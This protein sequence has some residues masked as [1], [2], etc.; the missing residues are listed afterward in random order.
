MLRRL[1]TLAL[2]AA[3]ACTGAGFAAHHT[4]EQRPTNS[5]GGSQPAT[6]PVKPPRSV[7]IVTTEL[8]NQVAV[9]RLPSLRIARRIDVAADPKTV[10]AQQL[11]GGLV[12][13]VSPG[14]G[15]VTVLN[16]ALRRTVV[17]HG[18]GSPQLAAFAPDGTHML[19]TDADRGV[20]DVLSLPERR[21]VGSVRVGAGAHH[22]AVSPDGRRA[23]VALGETASAIV[24]VDIHNPRH[25][26][27]LRV[28]HPAVAAHDLSFSPD[29]RTVWVSSADAPYVSVL[30]AT[31]GRELLRIP[32]GKAPQHVL[33]A[34]GRAYLTSGYGSSI[35]LVNP[36]TRRVIRRVQAPYGSFNLA[37]AG[38]LL[39]VTS[40]LNGDVTELA[41]ATL[42]RLRVTHVAT[43]ARS[44][45]VLE[46]RTPAGDRP[47]YCARSG[48]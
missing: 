30:R 25:P 32:A 20:L 37:A 8:R 44:V 41:A 19:V 26:H 39:V 15:T 43:V 12:A 16:P 18:F 10:A 45:A 17:L 22:L 36:R 21:I 7:A 38:D 46:R 3:S 48:L 14:S 35:E 11:Q 27:V 33:F 29:G 47:I 23:W 34:D 6:Q 31:T 42:R 2:L 13:V 9:L 40:V 5:T 28:I 24:V 1:A 4:S